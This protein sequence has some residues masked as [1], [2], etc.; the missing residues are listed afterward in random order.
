[1]LNQILKGIHSYRYAVGIISKHKLWK[2][3]ILPSILSFITILLLI[4]GPTYAFMESSW[5]QQI[6]SWYPFEMG[7]EILEWILDGLFAIFVIAFMFFFLGK[8]IV[9][10]VVSPFMSILSEK[11]EFIHTGKL[12]KRRSNFISDLIRGIRIAIRNAL[13][14]IIITLLLLLF[15][16]IPGVGTIIGLGLTFIVQSFYA[17]FGNMDFT[18]ERKYNVRNSVNFVQAHKGLAIGNGSVFLLI[19]L[20]PVLGWVLAPVYGTVSAAVIILEQLKKDK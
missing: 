19:F 8:Y 5:E 9:M 2:Y 12:E 7:K 13:R 16:L 10:I 20:I 14:E 15:Q 11:I 1:M 18:L 3:V 17:G 6:L 4:V